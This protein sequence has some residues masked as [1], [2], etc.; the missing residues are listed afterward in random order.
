MKRTASLTSLF[1][2]LLV[3]CGPQVHLDDLDGDDTGDGSTSGSSATSGVTTT[4]QTTATATDPTAPTATDPTVPNDTTD[5]WDSGECPTEVYT[6][7]AE[8]PLS[9]IA[10]WVD[11]DGNVVRDGCWG[12]CEA[13]GI[14][15]EIQSCVV[16]PLDG[17]GSSDGGSGG[18]DT[19]G[20][21]GTPPP[22]TTGATTGGD[23]T[24][25][26]S[27][28]EDPLM[29]IE[30]EYIDYCLGGRGHASLRSQGRSN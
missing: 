19:G 12:A 21:D 25:T 20:D 2:A 7:V 10:E 24:A 4:P 5:D 13:A 1:A 16:T 22:D 3:G 23:P 28:G 14:Y 15:G 27:G 26:G 8:I 30:C 29:E 18:L 9:E 11:A 6:A 17:G